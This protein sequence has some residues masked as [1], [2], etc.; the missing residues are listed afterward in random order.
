MGPSCT[1]RCIASTPAAVKKER[2][3]KCNNYGRNCTHKW[4]HI[5]HLKAFNRDLRRSS[6]FTRIINGTH[7]SSP[8]D[9]HLLKEALIRWRLLVGL[10]LGSPVQ[11]S[12]V[13]KRMLRVQLSCQCANFQGRDST[14][15]SC[16][17]SPNTPSRGKANM[18]TQR[19]ACRKMTNSPRNVVLWRYTVVHSIT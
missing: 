11:L 12:S 10:A 7:C 8:Q 3:E 13:Q 2:R 19:E 4:K 14:L 17:S 5:G 16:G 1:R 6:L 15:C 18:R 9:T